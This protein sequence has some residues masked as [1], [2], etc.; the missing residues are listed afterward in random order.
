[1]SI[2][3]IDPVNGNDSTTAPLG[4]WSVAYTGGSGTEPVAGDILTG[5]TS[6]QTATVTAV[7]IT[8]GT[9][10]S[11]TA[12]GTMYVYGKSGTFVNEQV[13]VSNGAHY[14]ATTNFVVCAWK[15]LVSGATSSRIVAGDTIRIAKT[16][17]ATSIGDGTWTDDSGVVTLAT[18]Q[19]ITVDN[20]ETAWT[21]GGGDVA[22]PTKDSTTN[23]FMQGTGSAKFIFDS[24]VQINTKQA[25]FPLPATLDLSS[26]QIISFW[27]YTS[28]A[29]SGADRLRICLCSDAEGATVVDT[30][31]VP[32]TVAGC[33]EHYQVAR[34]SGGNL[35]AGI[36]SIALYTGGTSPGN[37]ITV[38]LD[39][40]IATTTNGLNH[41]SLISKN[42]SSTLDPAAEQWFA[43]RS[44]DDTTLT[45]DG[46][47]SGSNGFYSTIGT[48]PDTVTTYYRNP[49]RTMPANAASAALEQVTING[50]ASSRC[51]YTFG[52]D[53]T[54]NEQN[55]MTWYDGIVRTSSTYNVGR[56]F[57][58]I[59]KSY[60]TINGLG[61]VRF[62][63]GNNNSTQQRNDITM[64]MSL[65][66]YPY[67]YN[68]NT[69]S[70]GSMTTQMNNCNGFSSLFYCSV[71]N[72]TWKSYEINCQSPRFLG[73]YKNDI[74]WYIKKSPSSYV[75]IEYSNSRFKIVSYSNSYFLFTGEVS[76]ATTSAHNNVI[77]DCEFSAVT[78][79]TSYFLGFNN[80]ANNLCYNITANTA[81]TSGVIYVNNCGPVYIR[82][83]TTQDTQY[84]YT[85]S[86]SYGP[87][88]AQIDIIN[89]DPNLSR[90]V[91]NHGVAF[92]QQI[93]RHTVSGYAWQVDVTS[94]LAN[95][96]KPVT[97]NV[98]KV[99]CT[100]GK[101]VTFKAFVKKSDASDIGARLIVRAITPG[102]TTDQITTK[103]DD[104]NWE[105]L[106]VTFTPTYKCVVDV[107]LDVYWVANAADDSVYLDDITITEAE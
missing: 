65:V 77:H 58:G 13:D 30:I 102:I 46:G 45:I 40:I 55:G 43:L 79:S 75:P 44:I 42:S 41:G 18:A 95:I 74:E 59:S 26:K 23:N 101:L 29:I 104:T 80:T 36:N 7:T 82:N 31:S 93:E 89:G 100:G 72:I 22:T 61:I 105:E 47:A 67:D 81:C 2:F 12:S 24:A 70:N 27:M 87:A 84:V 10:A 98:A 32:V 76:T 37:S 20:C 62:R 96:A 85:V 83:L 86:D 3:Y 17:D 94:S 11:N 88:T 28:S 99:A 56:P 14:H 91:Y 15:T 21:T 35:G 78:G 9:W 57:L 66:F 19:T 69:F 54:T 103:A 63:S 4:W 6:N 64:A 97:V 49:L 33:W 50:S 106:T 8:T 39:N 38:Y 107:D 51:T 16:M 68:S 48:S 73:G 5:A 71:N 25:Y 52:W 1:M 34:T 92:M 53:P 60:I 90:T